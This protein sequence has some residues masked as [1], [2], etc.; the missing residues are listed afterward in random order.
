MGRHAGRG[1]ERLADASIALAA[2]GVEGP[3]AEDVGSY[4]CRSVAFV[5]DKTHFRYMRPFSFVCL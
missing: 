1:A 5:D 4:K 2:A 3:F